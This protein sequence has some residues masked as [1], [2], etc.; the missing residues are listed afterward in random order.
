ML[1][2][3]DPKVGRDL[4]QIGFPSVIITLDIHDVISTIW[5]G[6]DG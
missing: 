2:G 6:G 3:E 4:N 1:V 5:I